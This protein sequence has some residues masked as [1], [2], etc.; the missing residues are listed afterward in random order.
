V[1]DRHFWEQHH[2]EKEKEK[3]TGYSPNLIN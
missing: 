3:E 1:A 2:E